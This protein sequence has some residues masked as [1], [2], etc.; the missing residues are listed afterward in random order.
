MTSCPTLA[1]LTILS[2]TSGFNFT[3]VFDVLDRTPPL[4]QA[5]FGLRHK[6]QNTTILSPSFVPVTNQP[7]PVTTGN[8]VGS[9]T[10]PPV[11]VTSALTTKPATTVVISSTA[12]QS[13]PASTLPGC[14]AGSVSF[15]GSFSL[16][17]SNRQ[18]QLEYKTDSLWI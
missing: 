11:L 6:R 8:V 14:S 9:V 16:F 3:P 13:P 12:N 17:P 10:S 5:A 15:D 1:F 18:L 7:T 4:V 2:C